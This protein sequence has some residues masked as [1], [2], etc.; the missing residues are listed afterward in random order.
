VHDPGQLHLPVDLLAA[1][2]PQRIEGLVAVRADP[3][4]GRHIMDF[5]E[6]VQMRVVPPTVPTATRPLP[7]LRSITITIA[8][9]GLFPGPSDLCRSS[10]PAAVFS[11]EQPNSIRDNTAT[12]STNSSIR[13]SAEASRSSARS[14]RSRQDVTPATPTTSGSGP[15]RRS[16]RLVARTSI[17]T[18]ADRTSDTD[19]HSTGT[20]PPRIKPKPTAVVHTK[21]E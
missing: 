4:I 1:L 15:T 8:A 17:T 20:A 11:D 18:R 12:C 10:A 6:G 5:L 7:P 3:L 21:T 9:V 19:P 16:R 2:G 14:A 13:A